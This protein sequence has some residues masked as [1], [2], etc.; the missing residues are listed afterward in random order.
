MREVEFIAA[1]CS[2]YVQQ[3]LLGSIERPHSVCIAESVAGLEKLLNSD[4]AHV[5][6]VGPEWIAEEQRET[7]RLAHAAGAAVV[8]VYDG[9]VPVSVAA[10][11]VVRGRGKTG[12]LLQS[13]KRVAE[14]LAA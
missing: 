1:G 12:E 14:L 7:V 8:L 5:V 11:E 2:E 9:E 3:A 13:V 6:V 4:A 10:D